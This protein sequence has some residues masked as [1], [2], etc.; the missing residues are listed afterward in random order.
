MIRL[1]DSNTQFGSTSLPPH[2]DDL[3]LRGRWK[4]NLLMQDY[5]ISFKQA[6]RPFRFNSPLGK[7]KLL[8]YQFGAQ[9]NERG[10]PPNEYS[11]NLVIL[12]IN[13]NILSGI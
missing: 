11:C 6:N 5:L 8:L 10:Q 7:E 3:F 2:A 12:L 1:D 9:R 4:Q 13:N